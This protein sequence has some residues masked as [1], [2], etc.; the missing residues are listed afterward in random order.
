MTLDSTT[1]HDL[2]A[3]GFKAKHHSSNAATYNMK[4]SQALGKSIQCVTTFFKLHADDS[5]Q[6]HYM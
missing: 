4:E 6:S 1:F 3:Y 5:T 2:I